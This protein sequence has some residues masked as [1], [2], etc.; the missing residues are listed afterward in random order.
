MLG[1]RAITPVGLML[2]EMATNAVKYGAWSQPG[3]MISVDWDRAGAEIVLKWRESGAEIAEMPTRQ[4]F[5]SQLMT[6][7]ARQLG[8]SI[9]REFAASG[10]VIT[11]RFPADA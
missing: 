3:G 4:G 1:V 10:V 5:G 8:G 2:H 6:S 9:E 11:I 7:S